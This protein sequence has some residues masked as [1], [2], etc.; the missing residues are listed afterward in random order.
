MNII[1]LLKKVPGDKLALAHKN[2]TINYHQLN[3]KSRA[4][5][6]CLKQ[7]GVNHQHSALLF[8]P[9]SLELYIIFLALI[10]IGCT[11]VLVDPTASKKNMRHAIAQ[12]KPDVF[13]AIPKAHLLR[14]YPEIR[15]INLKFAI[16]FKLPATK[17]ID[18]DRLVT[19]HD[20]IDFDAPVT[21]PALI[22]F[23]SGS[24]GVPKGIC[25]SHGF[26]IE[27]HMAITNNLPI[28][29][30][31]IEFTT[32]PVFILSNLAA[33]ITSII[34][35]LKLHKLATIA[36]EK[37]S[38][39]LQQFNCNR[40]LAAPNFCAQLAQYLLTNQQSNTTIKNIYTGGGPVFPN[41]LLDFKKAFPH[42][43]IYSVYG[44]TEAEPIAHI[45]LNELTSSSLNKMRQGFGLLAGKPVVEITLAVI[46]SDSSI[47]I[48]D[49]MTLSE[50]EKL[51]LHNQAGE[52]IVTGKH[53]QKAYLDGNSH[54]T[55]IKVDDQI[56]HRT[57][58]AGYLDDNGQLWLLGRCSAK[59]LK[60]ERAIYPFSIEAAAMTFEK[61][62][63]AAVI[64]IEQKII[65]VIE[66]LQNSAAKTCQQLKQ[67]LNDI[68]EVRV[69]EKIPMDKR[70]H[71]KVLYD[72]LRKIALR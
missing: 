34:P 11:V 8:I 9:L 45:S 67:Q 70:H 14:L 3:E 33:G 53:V 40:L 69:V 12:V 52:I 13:I 39:P 7:H 18:L 41:L 59:I 10:R 17:Y 42:A 65:L 54:N 1:E 57:G 2:Q 28:D 61:V 16:R 49:V 6:S 22:T 32:L 19:P 51:K 55:K 46:T 29:P 5:A 48:S 30:A 72:E 27:Q 36:P 25:R 56:W 71:S 20:S 63:R 44:S 68:D 66:C 38:Q 60:K 50:F 21:H 24:T 43:T 15:A 64:E 58:D 62:K 35:A 31:D 26:L 4:V 23:T 47:G 37:V